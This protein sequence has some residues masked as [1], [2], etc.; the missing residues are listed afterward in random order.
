MTA[1]HSAPGQSIEDA[2]PQQEPAHVVGLAIQ[3]LLDEVVDDEAIVSGE[4]RD[5]AVDVVPTLHGQGRQLERGDPTLGALL[6]RGHLARLEVQPAASLRYARAS[7]R[8][9]RRS[10]ART[11]TSCPCALRRAS[12]NGGSARVAITTCADGGRCSSRN[13]I[14]VLDV[15]GVD[16]VEVIKDE[17][18]LVRRRAELIH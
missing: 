17:D 4:T 10:A 16:H 15:A 11:S 9:N 7:S 2:G 14:P 13:A 18:E 3:D 8:V 5:E 12:G 6:Q 1:S